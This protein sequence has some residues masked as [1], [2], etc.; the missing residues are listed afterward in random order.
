MI[1]NDAAMMLTGTGEVIRRHIER[2]GHKSGHN[3][4]ASAE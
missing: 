4:N 2:E 1:L 3:D